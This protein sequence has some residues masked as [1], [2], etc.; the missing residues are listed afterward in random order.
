M[1]RVAIVFLVHSV[2]PTRA[3]VVALALSFAKS[4]FGAVVLFRPESFWDRCSL[5]IKAKYTDH[6][7]FAF[8]SASV[9]FECAK[10]T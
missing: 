3:T 4:V 2:F 8:S 9:C 7:G 10:S 6:A 5:F 1:A